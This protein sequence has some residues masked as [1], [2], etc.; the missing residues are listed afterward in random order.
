MQHCILISLGTNINRAHHARSG[1]DALKSAFSSITCSRMYES[2]AV[3]FPG[4]PFYNCVVRAF[5]ALSVEDVVTTLKSIER[6]N[7]RT[8]SEKKFCSRTLDLDLLTYDSRVCAQPVVLP[9]E[10]ILYN[11]FVLQ[12]LSELVPEEVHPLKQ[13]TYQQLWQAFDN[14]S[15]KLWP[16]DFTWSES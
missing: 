2:E 16:I 7:G 15:Q 6:K 3:G 8:H 12:P 13:K 10:E 11:A 1:L 14:T 5:T 4:S 9:R